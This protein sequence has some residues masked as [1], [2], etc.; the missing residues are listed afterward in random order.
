MAPRQ[1]RTITKAFTADGSGTAFDWDGGWGVL[2]AQ[3]TFGGGTLKL[4]FSED[5]G[6]TWTALPADTQLTAA[7]SAAFLA[8]VGASL[9]ITLAGATNPTIAAVVRVGTPQ[10]VG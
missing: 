2:N 9:R 6:S 8:G 3:G 4:E 1:T 10:W 7:G 5:S